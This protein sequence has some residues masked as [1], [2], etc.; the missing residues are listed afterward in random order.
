MKNLKTFK[1]DVLIDEK[2]FCNRTKEI[3][4]LTKRAKQSKRTVLFAPRRYGKTSLVKNV[5]GNR[6]RKASAKGVLI[7]IDLMDVRSFQSISERLQ[8]GIAKSLS[9]HFPIRTLIKSMAGMLKHLSLSI[10][11]DPITGQPNMNF[12]IKDLETQKGCRQLMEAMKKLSNK[13]HLMVV[14]D[15]FQDISFVEE[16][17]AVFR[18]FL[19]E[20]TNSSIFILGSKK[21][22]LKLMFSDVN[23]PLFNF[24]DE[25]H[26]TPIKSDEWL[27]YFSERLKQVGTKIGE[28]EIIWIMNQMYNV[29][30][31]ICELGAWLMD[32]CPNVT[33]AIDKIKNEL[34]EMVDSKQSYAYLLQTYTE[35][36]RNV[37]KQ[38]AISK[39]VLEPYSMSFLDSLRVSKSSVG[40]I[41]KKLMDLGTIEFENDK[42]YRISDPILGYYLESH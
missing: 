7:Y 4:T 29:P 20:I 6:Y 25:I 35:N 19:Q 37:L 23:A 32:E 8:H 15:E 31:A 40:K 22:L 42:G 26:L 11:L 3:A 41:I 2:D 5:I 33:L 38:I 1:Y 14:L 34:S 16:A 13:F 30:N 9:Q 36:E 28:E 18:S 24:G 17:E 39:F 10:N 12:G 21:H 27:S